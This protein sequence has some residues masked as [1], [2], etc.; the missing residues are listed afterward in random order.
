[1]G[2]SKRSR[3][4]ILII[5]IFLSIIIS[6][7]GI[8]YA[9]RAF[10]S[11]KYFMLTKSPK[12]YYTYVEKY[13]LYQLI[14]SLPEKTTL[15]PKE[16]A[17]D[18]SSTVTLQRE[19]LDSVLLSAFG[20]SLED[21]EK[22]LGIPF[23]NIGFDTSLVSKDHK[24]NEIIKLKLNETKLLTTDILLN[25]DANELSMQFPELSDAY[26]TRTLDEE[27][28]PSDDE[29]AFPSPST[30]LLGN[31]S[32]RYLDLFFANITNVTLTKEVPLSL[33]SLSVECNQ[34]TITLSR[35][36]V[37][38][39]TAT[40]FESARSDTDV[41]RLL[42]LSHVPKEQYFKVLDDIE[43][44]IK[45]EL[46]EHSP[47]DTVLMKLYVDKQGYILGREITSFGYS[48]L[49]YTFLSD[50]TSQEYDIRLIHDASGR[51]LS[52]TGENKKIGEEDQGSISLLLGDPSKSDQSDTSVK[53][54]YEN[55]RREWTDGHPYLNGKFTLSSAQLMGLHITSDF[56]TNANQQLNTTSIRLG[57]SPLV[58]IDSTIIPRAAVQLGEAD[59]DAARYD[60]SQYDQYLADINLKEYLRSVAVSLGI[61]PERLIGLYQFA[62]SSIN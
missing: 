7:A 5:L 21:A 15:L 51:L 53:L 9:N 52:I 47:E 20:I 41:F 18:T 33:N 24:T 59:S 38:S 12:E 44:R 11:N 34:L 2:N 62:G 4:R 35:D 31:I 54:T 3:R 55:V 46:Q 45:Q 43:Y 16:Y 17:Y 1:M 6:G 23:K 56:S 60:I 14:N 10:L 26:L 8:A 37:A 50:D 25:Y 30:E 48:T 39:L 28:A 58:T 32:K 36:E 61:D 13:G 57:A 19:E 40:L 29:D 42:Q 49:S 27:A 22:L